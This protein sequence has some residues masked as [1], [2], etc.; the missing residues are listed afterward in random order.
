MRFNRNSK[1]V[2]SRSRDN[3]LKRE[4]TVALF[5]GGEDMNLGIGLSR[6][7]LN[8]RTSN[9]ILTYFTINLFRI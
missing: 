9:V 3:G 2:R 4:Q 5:N 6:N 1:R 8:C 7:P